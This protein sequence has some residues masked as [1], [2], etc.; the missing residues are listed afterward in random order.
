MKNLSKASKIKLIILI[1]V[2]SIIIGLFSDILLT[3]IE[4]LIYQENYYDLVMKY[5]S[6]YRVPPELVFAVINVES[7]YDK[8]AVSS[9][10]AIGLMQ[11][12][13]STY[14]WIAS[15]FGDSANVS[16]LYI[17]KVNVE[18][19]TYYLRYLYDIFDCSWEKALIAYNWGMGNFMRFI[20]EHGYI[21]GDFGSIPI[22][23]TRN[24]VR[25]V[26][27]HWEKYKEIYN[28]SANN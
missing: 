23:E 21:E 24:Y 25:K 8:N 5:S 3:C 19:G 4:K 11:I 28:N 6:K 2:I 10:G 17:P 15:I 1:L 16:R 22:S 26:L 9:A 20:E 14:E 12:M 7:N 27:Y 18:Y 13:P